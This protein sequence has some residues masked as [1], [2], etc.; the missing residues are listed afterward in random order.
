MKSN[1]L[2]GLCF[3]LAKIDS[4]DFTRLRD[5]KVELRQLRNRILGIPDKFIVTMEDIDQRVALATEKLDLEKGR[6]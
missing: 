1:A 6:K 5:D 4:Y 2:E 3:V